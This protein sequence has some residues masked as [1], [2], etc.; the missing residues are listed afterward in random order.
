MYIVL[1]LNLNPQKIM[2]T[3]CVMGAELANVQ[4]AMSSRLFGV[5]KNNNISSHL[6]IEI[7][8]FPGSFV[9][10][11]MIMEISNMFSLQ[12]TWRLQNHHFFTSRFFL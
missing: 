4:N 6:L 11:E 10:T 1:E 5:I 8:S 12:I 3:F 9:M 2:A 7:Y